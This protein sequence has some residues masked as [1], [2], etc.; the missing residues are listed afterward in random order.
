[1]VG[2]FAYV[3]DGAAGTHVID[4]SNP[5]NP[6]LVGTSPTGGW[7]WSVFVVDG[8]A[9]IAAEEEGLRVVD[10]A[11]PARPRQISSFLT[12]GGATGVFVEEGFA[13]VAA[14]SSGLW[15]LNVTRPANPVAVGVNKTEYA[16]NVRVKE[17]FAYVA[18]E[19]KGVLVIDV[20]NPT[21]LRRLRR[22]APNRSANMIDI[23]GDNLFV[24]D[25]AGGLL[26][27]SL[28]RSK[29]EERGRRFIP[30]QRRSR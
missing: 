22:F 28:S 13:Y 25:G 8:V 17:G 21:R 10:V 11:D 23:E 27:V 9:Y 7:D 15:I 12:S 20:K 18:T 1:V 26:A 4:V 16:R 5:S 3:A 2:A 19:R 30:L 24:A 14:G 6:V 29:A